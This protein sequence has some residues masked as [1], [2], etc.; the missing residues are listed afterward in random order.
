MGTRIFDELHQV[1]HK[2][3]CQD[4]PSYWE[5]LQVLIHTIIHHQSRVDAEWYQ[6][7]IQA[8]SNCTTLIPES[9]TGV[10][11]QRLVATLFC[12][13]LAVVV[14]THMH[15]VALVALGIPMHQFPSLPEASTHQD[16]PLPTFQDILSAG[17]LHATLDEKFR[18]NPNVTHAPFVLAKDYN[19]SSPAWQALPHDVQHYMLE[20]MV[21]FHPLVA[22]SLA[23]TAAQLVGRMNQE[24][25]LPDKVVLEPWK[26]LDP[27]QYCTNGMTRLDAEILMVAVAQTYGTQY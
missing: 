19:T 17:M 10:V 25:S 20:N 4:P 7:T 2:N 27:T 15:H 23:P 11:R 6:L 5:T 8:L 22:L 13:V 24:I 1:K 21:P 14:A 12:E 18:H 26:E 16:T 3:T 9:Y